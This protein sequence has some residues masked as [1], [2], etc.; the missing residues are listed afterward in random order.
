M[1][2]KAR[3]Q[4]RTGIYHIML[5]GINQQTI[6]EDETDK[7]QFLQ[8]LKRYKE[9]CHFKLYSYC[10]M[11]NHVHLLLEEGEESFSQSLKRIS[12]SYVYWY[13][14]KYDRSGHLFQGRFNSE[15]VNDMD[16][17]LTVVRYIH[18]NPLKAAVVRTVWDSKWTSIHAYLGR[19]SDLVDT[20]KVLAL[21]AFDDITALKCYKNFMEEVNEDQC[22]D[23]ILKTRVQ[24]CEVREHLM[25]LGVPHSSML[26][27]MERKKRNGILAS[28]KSIEGVSCRQ[29]SRVT[30]ISKSVVGRAPG[31]GDRYVVPSGSERVKKQN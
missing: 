17:F 20:E 12:S 18:Q 1:P 14:L 7:R 30:G 11:D 21:L 28:L 10:I 25:N 22:L 31:P 19:R 4:S 15:C 5:R 8:T 16:Y 27:Q 9:L 29:I 3:K 23:I 24:D 2:R 26:Q 6:F 13:N